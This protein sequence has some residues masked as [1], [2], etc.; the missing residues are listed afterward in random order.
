MTNSCKMSNIK[1][2]LGSRLLFKKK[3]EFIILFNKL[4]CCFL[5]ISSIFYH[6]SLRLSKMHC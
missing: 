2:C 1:F 6:I 3:I 5:T 4:I